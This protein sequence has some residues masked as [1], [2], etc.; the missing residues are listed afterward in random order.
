MAKQ[1]NDK[2]LSL[3]KLVSFSLPSR[4]PHATCAGRHLTSSWQTCAI[5]P[6]VQLSV[7]IQILQIRYELHGPYRI[8]ESGVKSKSEKMRS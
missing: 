4:Q 7:F 2:A 5:L 8:G 6:E 3:F 1:Y